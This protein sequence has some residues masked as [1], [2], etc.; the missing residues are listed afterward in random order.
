M[1][2]H[3]ISSNLIYSSENDQFFKNNTPIKNDKDMN[4]QRSEFNSLIKKETSSFIHKS[5]SNII[6]LI[7]AG[8]SV[9][10]TGGTVD[11]RFGK[12]VSMLAALINDA[13]KLDPSLF[14]LQQLADLCKYD[15]PVEI[16]DAAENV[17]LNSTFNL[18][19]FL[20]NLL[21]FEKYVSASEHNKYVASKKK[22]LSLIISNTSY[23]YDSSCLKHSAFINTVSHLVKAPSKLTIVT[24]NYDTLIED[25]A[26]SIGYTVMDGFSFSHRPYFDSDMFE[27]NLVKDIENIKTRELEYKKNILN[28]LKLHGS[29]TW[30]RDGQGIR[31]KE[32]SDVIEPIM[33]FPSSEKYM[34]SYQDP[35]FEL[36]AKFQELLKR[37]NTLLI[38]SG[39]S[40]ADNHISQMI[41]QAILHNKS[42]ALLISDYNINQ[43]NPNWDKLTDLMKHNYQIAFLQATMNSDLTDYLG[44]YYDD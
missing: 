2:Q 44:E 18:E 15:I 38:T 8:A 21:S 29:L 24:T 35:Y 3:Y 10:C 32:K 27:W 26:D 30:K 12:T 6:V 5:F 31:R 34:Q 7:G 25:A 9:L 42:L 4:I 28:L 40:F 14:T 20:S 19:D 1:N 23:D 36:F 33:I 37:P 11:P 22:I 43:S 13:L 39:F 17:K 16:S 41:I